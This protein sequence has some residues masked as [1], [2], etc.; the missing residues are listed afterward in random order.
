MRLTLIPLLLLVCG[1]PRADAEDA[2]ATAAVE[3]ELRTMTQELLDAIAPGNAA[4]WDRYVDDAII[5][6]DETGAVRGK[7]ELLATLTPLPPGLNGSIG[8]DTFRVSLHGDVAVVAHEDQEHLDYY[9]QTLASRFRSLDTWRKTP[10]GWRL[11]A[12]QTTAVLK[13]PPSMTLPR[14]ALCAF[15][16]RYRLTDQIETTIVCDD[17]GLVA[18]REGRPDVR[19]LA[20]TADMFFA[21]GQP[22]T[23]RYFRRDAGGAVMGFVDRREGE[24]ILWRR[25]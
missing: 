7:A 10:Q 13:D 8:I 14:E 23:R 6:V 5:H 2:A 25:E 19:Y 15:A 1:A 3:N 20:E 9:G 4:L 16:G 21:A 24:D 18:R 12:E 17:Q 11:I 22:R